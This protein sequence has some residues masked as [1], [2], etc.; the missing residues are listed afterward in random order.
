MF[1][2][3]AENLLGDSNRKAWLVPKNQTRAIL[4]S[5]LQ[6]FVWLDYNITARGTN[7]Q[8]IDVWMAMLWGILWLYQTRFW[9]DIR[10]HNLC[11]FEGLVL[12]WIVK[13]DCCDEIAD[14]MAPKRQ[15]SPPAFKWTEEKTE[16][17]LHQLIEYQ[18]VNGHGQKII[19]P[20]LNATFD[21]AMNVKCNH[22]T[23]KNRYQG[24]KREYSAW[25]DLKNQETGLGW[26]DAKGTID[27]SEDWWD[28]KIKVSIGH[29]L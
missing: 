23:L 27:A 5:S 19:W 21:L 22:D 4:S 1:D 26:D 14:D 17:F 29:P 3:L 7:L 25:M 15:R 20:V 18:L 24:L 2:W 11:D 9:Q 28:K 10:K 12:D 8:L 6:K 13:D 16:F